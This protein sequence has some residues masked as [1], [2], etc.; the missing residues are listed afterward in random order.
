ML[1]ETIVFPIA[2]A[3]GQQS[4]FIKLFLIFFSQYPIGWIMHYFI[5]GRV[6]RHLYT[7]II[8]LLIQ[9]YMFGTD[10]LHVVLMAGVAYAMMLF[11]KRD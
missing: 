1:D 4:A 7:I 9:M 10:T 8:G 11:M 5:H 2:N 3:I 6:I